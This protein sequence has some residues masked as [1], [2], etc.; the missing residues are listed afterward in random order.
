MCNLS[1]MVYIA[2]ISAQFYIS[3][4]EHTTLTQN[5]KC[6]VQNIWPFCFIFSSLFLALSLSLQ[7]SCGCG[8]FHFQYINLIAH[9][10]ICFDSYSVCFTARLHRLM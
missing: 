9:W 8:K 6:A 1:A 5:I 7:I 4:A 2:P 3:R 10:R